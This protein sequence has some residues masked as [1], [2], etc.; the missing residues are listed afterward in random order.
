MHRALLVLFA[1]AACGPVEDD[2]EQEPESFKTVE[3]G[4]I[5]C[6]THQDTGYRS[7]NPFTITLVTVDG[8]PVERNTANAFSVMA[9]AA[10]GAG[11]QIRVNDGFRTPQEQQY[12]YNCYVTCSCNSCNAAAAPGYSNHQS[13]SAL[14]LNTSSGGV[15]NWLSANGASYGFHRTVPSEA[16]HWEYQGGGPGGGPC[17]D[18]CD[19]T[20]GPFTFSCDGPQAGMHCANVNEPGD[21]N[22]WA[23]NFFCTAQDL[24]LRWSSAGDLPG[25][26]C[27][28]V[29]ESAEVYASA[30]AD[31]RICVP[32][33]SPWI[34]TFSSAGPIAG[35][36]CAQWNEP[37]D[38]NS[39]GDNFLC[40]EPRMDFSA[41]GFT[42]SGNGPRAGKSCILVNEPSDPDTWNDN[43]FCS[44]EP[45]GMRWSF[46]SPIAGM[47]CT[48]VSE[49]AEPLASIWADNYLCIPPEQPWRFTWSS[50][51]PIADK[52]CVR[53]FEHAEA[54]PTWL[55]NWLCVD[56]LP[57]V[58]LEPVVWVP[59]VLTPEPQPQPPAPA[60]GND[61]RMEL[62]SRGCSAFSPAHLSAFALVAWLLRRKR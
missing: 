3:Q 54:N 45:T 40:A 24:G 6:A 32:K 29:A 2:F 31:N 12:Y 13:G 47:I 60:G 52:T 41:G 35:Q 21:P 58:A 15:Y 1:F 28:A 59:G 57:A 36:Q 33:Q 5:S 25:M 51:G 17:V 43:Y 62:E 48:N 4:L 11:V 10:A 8:Q 26:D 55:D 46:N 61:T 27:T 30:W 38:P 37:A 53:W 39:W 16:W 42:F 14:D 44:D 34:F 56:R 49:S 9:A 18:S 23:D 20:A 19:R 50:A 22:S 7:G